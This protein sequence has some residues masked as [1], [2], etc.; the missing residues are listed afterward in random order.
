MTRLEQ[1][2]A[3]ALRGA[4]P[5]HLARELE[6]LRAEHT[7][8]HIQAMSTEMRLPEA[9]PEMEALFDAK[10]FDTLSDED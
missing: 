4:M 2:E 1:L 10:P 7:Q 8:Q 3:R 6:S 5:K 9:E